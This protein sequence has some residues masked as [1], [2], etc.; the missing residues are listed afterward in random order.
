MHSHIHPPKKILIINTFGVGDVLFTTPLMRNLKTSFPGIFIGYIC[1]RRTAALLERN[2]NVDRIF[3]YERDEFHSVY[4]RSKLALAAKF[5]R[6]LNEVRDERF[7][8][9]L[10]V[11]LSRGTAFLTWLIGIKLRIGFSYK[12]RGIFLNRKIPLS[13]YEGKHV[14]DYYLSLLQE[15]GGVVRSRELELTLNADDARWAEDFI[16]SNRVILKGRPVIGIVPGGGASWG[17]ESA[18]KRWPAEKFA[19]LAD[20]LIEKF[21]AATILMGDKNETDLC[22]E[23]AGRMSHQPVM[24]CGKTT[25]TQFAALAKKCSLMVVNDGGPLHIAVASGVRTVSIF[26]PVSEEVYGPYPIGN[27]IVVNKAIACRPCYRNFRRARCE[28]ISCLNQLTVEEVSE[29]IKEAL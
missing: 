3:I 8:L 28:H 29:R 15:I 9:V 5:R 6:F 1:N 21:S 26:G 19:K 7:D 20:K 14:V 11:S 12:N 23:V 18:F 27:N 22:S 10:D 13:G 17:R 2:A 4:Q 25:I 16:A 24:A